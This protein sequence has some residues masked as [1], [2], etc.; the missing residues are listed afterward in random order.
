M[1]QENEL[2]DWLEEALIAIEQF[3][4][5]FEFIFEQ[6]IFE[7]NILRVL[8]HASYGIPYRKYSS[9]KPF[10]ENDMIFLNGTGK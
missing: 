4:R 6:F 8:H 5:I 1:L 3:I 9:E 10:D 7:E 2:H